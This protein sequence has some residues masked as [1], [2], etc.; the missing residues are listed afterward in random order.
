[1]NEAERLWRNAQIEDKVGRGYDWF[2]L[3]MAKLQPDEP[4]T[5]WD[6]DWLGFYPTQIKAFNLN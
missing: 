4:E 6:R 2:K 5:R 1:M 3:L